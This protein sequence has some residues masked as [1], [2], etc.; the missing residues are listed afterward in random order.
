[1]V[2]V[3]GGGGDVAVVELFRDDE[4]PVY[5]AGEFLPIG[6]PLFLE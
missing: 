1:V 3:V 4:L 2:V 5:G 6:C